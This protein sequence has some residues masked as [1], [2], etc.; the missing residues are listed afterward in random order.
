[1]YLNRSG[2]AF[3]LLFSFG[4]DKFSWLSSKGQLISKANFQT[5]N[6]SKKWTREFVFTTMRRVFVCF[7]EEIEDTKKNFRNYLTFKNKLADRNF[8]FQ[9]ILSQ[10]SYPDVILIQHLVLKLGFI[11]MKLGQNWHK[12][13]IKRHG[14]S[15][16]VWVILRGMESF[17]PKQFMSFYSKFMSNV[18]PA[19][20]LITRIYLDEIGIKL[21]LICS[22][23]NGQ[24]NMD[25]P[26]AFG[27]FSEEW[28]A[29][30]IWS[31]TKR[32]S[33]TAMLVW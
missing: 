8:R 15:F 17:G 19:L 29:L 7:L 30:A 13:W 3:I 28:R 5:V 20:F 10:F 1:M 24:K 25:C 16:S 18:G 11:W 21:I 26:L 23:L 14:L 6:S 27:E 4:D 9:S 33:Q 12:L 2:P 22:K 32:T 31:T